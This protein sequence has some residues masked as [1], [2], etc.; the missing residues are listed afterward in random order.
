MI[1]KT[2]HIHLKMISVTL[3][4]IYPVSIVPL[5]GWIPLPRLQTRLSLHSNSKLSSFCFSEVNEVWGQVLN[6]QSVDNLNDLS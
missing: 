5:D 4:V 6:F 3:N 1:G 2:K